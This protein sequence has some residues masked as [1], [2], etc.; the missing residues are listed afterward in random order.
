[1]RQTRNSPLPN[2]R[3]LFCCLPVYR[4]GNQHFSLKYLMV[5]TIWLV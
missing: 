2:G 1:M 3:G 4:V 5:R